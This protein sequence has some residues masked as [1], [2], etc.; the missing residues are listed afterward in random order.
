MREIWDEDNRDDSG[1]FETKFENLKQSQ[2]VKAKFP[3]SGLHPE[4]IFY[5]VSNTS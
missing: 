2:K 3:Q 5:K 4:N 1:I